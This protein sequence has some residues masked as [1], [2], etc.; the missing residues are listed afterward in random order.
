[1]LFRFRLLIPAVAL[2]LVAGWLFSDDLQESDLPGA[3]KGL[4]QTLQQLQ[5]EIKQ[6]Q[7]SVKELSRHAKKDKSFGP[8]PWPTP[9]GAASE[10]PAWQRVQE[11]YDRARR[12]EDLKLYGPA[13]EAY[14]QAIELDPQNDSAF[15][16]RGL[17]HYQLADYANAASDLSRSL[18]IQPNN[19]RAYATRASVLAATGQMTA[20]LA[21]ANE[22]IL[23]AKNSEN[24]TL[25]AE[26][27]ELRKETQQAIDDY[28]NAIATARDSE[29]AYLGRAAAFRSQNHVDQSLADCNQ[30]IQLR[31]GDAAAYLCRAESYLLSGSLNPAIEDVN[32]A[33]LMGQNTSHTAALLGTAVQ[34]LQALAAAS[35]E[36]RRQQEAVEVRQATPT[37]PTEQRTSGTTPRTENVQAASAV[38]PLSPGLLPE[39]HNVMVTPPNALA[40][41]AGRDEA[42]KI[43]DRYNRR[44]R[45]FSNQG[46]FE[47]AL[48]ILNQAIE[49]DP[50]LAAA[51][52][53]RGYVELRL[54]NYERAIRDFSEAIRLNPGYANAYHNRAVARGFAGDQAGAALDFRRAAELE[55]QPSRKQ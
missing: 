31:P 15:F 18:A 40:T 12:S 33:I 49:I 2:L 42:R 13:I 35:P 53:A 8:F 38:L 52:N 28:T 41:R 54:R 6:L 3:I 37:G 9:G 36:P 50:D 24:Y 27:H 44:G 39:T 25:R 43:A 34:N 32:R 14:T 51:Q 19:S 26:L 30:A 5:L 1:M 47:E 22:A 21:D 4:Q 48:R 16:H 23:K 45:S 46:K 11:A 29:K 7:T 20:A 55:R 10:A 17:C